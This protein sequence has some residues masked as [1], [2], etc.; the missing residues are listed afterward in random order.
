MNVPINYYSSNFWATR[1]GW[2]WNLFWRWP[3]WLSNLCTLQ[4]SD[5]VDGWGS[6][7]SHLQAIGHTGGR[8]PAHPPEPGRTQPTLPPHDQLPQE[9][10]L[11]CRHEEDPERIRY[12]IITVAC[13]SC[14]YSNQFLCRF[15]SFGCSDSNKT[16]VIKIYHLYNR[17]IDSLII[18]RN[19][20]QNLLSTHIRK[21]D[22]CFWLNF[23]K[24]L[25][26]SFNFDTKS[27]VNQTEERTTSIKFGGTGLCMC[28][29]CS[30]SCVQENWTLPCSSPC[31]NRK[32]REQPNLEVCTQTFC[33]GINTE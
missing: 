23:S 33:T 18:A 17:L 6:N 19:V 24:L 14:L 20:K 25:D 8:E 21:S 3:W 12:I 7:D 10:I 16:I 29:T 11:T 30:S 9:D 13:L 15:G 22:Q 4:Y 5:S 1:K 28:T 27:Y 26:A 31:Y 32:N 2:P